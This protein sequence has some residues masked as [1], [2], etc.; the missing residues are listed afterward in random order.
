MKVIITL[1]YSSSDTNKI[2]QELGAI[3]CSMGETLKPHSSA[4]LRTLHG[5]DVPG[6]VHSRINGMA[7]FYDD[8]GVPIQF[9]AIR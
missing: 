5:L 2:G 9:W 3:L 7:T 1:N 6:Q 4:T 8:I